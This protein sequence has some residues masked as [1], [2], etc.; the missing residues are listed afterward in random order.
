MESKVIE[1]G[2]KQCIV[3]YISDDTGSMVEPE[4]LWNR[5]AGHATQLNADGWGIVST[6]V[7]PMR[8]AG[9]AGN[10]LFQSGGQYATQVAVTV[11]YAR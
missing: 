9:T 7:M 10:M 11:V 8:Q 1:V 6:S 4:P 5:I 2:P 3:L